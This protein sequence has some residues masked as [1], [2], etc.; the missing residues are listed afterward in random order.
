MAAT[1]AAVESER[2]M[3]EPRLVMRRD[4]HRVLVA[5]TQ[6][7]TDYAVR[8]GREADK[9]AEQD[10]LA[11]PARVLERLRSLRLPGGV[12]P[13]SDARLLRVA[14]VASQNAAVSSRQ[15]IYPRGMEAIRALK[16]SQGAL[17][18][19]ALLRIDE[20]RQRISGRYS[21]AEQLP[22]RPELDELLNL[23]H[24]RCA[25]G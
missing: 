21:E 12:E 20:I 23:N 13:L 1:R 16:L 10:P 15:E 24:P 7:L 3:T 25:G 5:T 4:R 8:L 9:F 18:G 11:P 14:A 19:T 22:D 6:G 2:T 17:L